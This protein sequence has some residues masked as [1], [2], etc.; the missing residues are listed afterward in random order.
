M[1]IPPIDTKFLRPSAKGQFNKSKETFEKAYSQALD[2]LKKPSDL[3]YIPVVYAF[4]FVLVKEQQLDTERILILRFLSVTSVDS[5]GVDKLGIYISTYVNELDYEDIVACFATELAHFIYLK[6]EVKVDP[7]LLPAHMDNNDL[8]IN[9][10]QEEDQASIERALFN[11][12]VFSWLESF[13]NKMRMGEP[14]NKVK[15]HANTMRFGNFLET[16][17]GEKY[18]ELKTKQ[19]EKIKSKLK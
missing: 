4:P 19:L 11:D 14:I 10:K 3:A 17:L 7:R 9:E 6:G 16:V 18:A 5:Y 8:D 2:S 12:P 13:D 1:D 15:D